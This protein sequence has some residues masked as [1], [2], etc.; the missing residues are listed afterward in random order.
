[1]ASGC[2]YLGHGDFGTSP[3][4]AWKRVY[5]SRDVDNARPTSPESGQDAS[6]RVSLRPLRTRAGGDLRTY[7]GG[8]GGR[9]G[10]RKAIG[11]SDPAT[12][13]ARPSAQ[14]G[15]TRYRPVSF[16]RFVLEAAV[17]LNSKY[18]T[19]LIIEAASHES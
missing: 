18:S 19:V 8:P 6:A 7:Q 4:T 1:M 15:I 5:F 13:F 2:R 9:Q 10:A 11:T 3:L 16:Q 14:I 17:E 12:R